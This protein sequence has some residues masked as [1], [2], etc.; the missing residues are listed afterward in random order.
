MQAVG[1]SY[2]EDATRQ[3][4]TV[5][6]LFP[7]ILKALERL[8]R[9]PGIEPRVPKG[10]IILSF[11]K[12][13]ID[14]LERIC[15]LSATQAQQTPTSMPTHI[16]DRAHNLQHT[17]AIVP[18]FPAAS[19]MRASCHACNERRLKCDGG[20]PDCRNCRDGKREC[21]RGVPL[22]FTKATTTNALFTPPTENILRLCEFAI[23]LMARL[24]T[25][26]STHEEIREGFMFFLLQK[27]G[28][29]L[30]TFSIGPEHEWEVGGHEAQ[31]DEGSRQ[32]GEAQEV[33][34]A[35]APYLVWI[36]EQALAFTGPTHL[37]RS[38]S[39]A[40]PST[41]TREPLLA[42]EQRRFQNTM[43]RAMFGDGV[44]ADYSPTLTPPSSPLDRSFF[45]RLAGELQTGETG[46]K[47]WYKHEVWRLVSWDCLKEKLQWDNI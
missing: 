45:D 39:N 20:L 28:Q 43:L 15:D 10:K 14:V 13:F 26:K 41:S 35:Q 19:G 32:L 17:I 21:K 16:A 46:I 3:L 18:G 30:R 22:H 36:F 6:Q 44:S 31:A 38:S 24:D 34:E 2:S 47:D 42:L 5:G 11:V 4:L 37:A 12:I 8:N 7:C 25:T 9:P 40:G 33:N 23:V 1:D 29:G 27:L